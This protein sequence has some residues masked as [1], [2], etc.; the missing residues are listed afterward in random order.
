M[1]EIYY[2]GGT[3]ARTISS[4]DISDAVAAR[5][6]KADYYESRAEIPAVISKSAK[7]GDIV[8]V[9]GARDATLADFARQL[10]DAL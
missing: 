5:G 10:L 6:R 8:V 1:P 4:K 9:I 7:P 2:A 3:V